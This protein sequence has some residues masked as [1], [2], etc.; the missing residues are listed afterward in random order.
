MNA[1][2]IVL[3]G[4]FVTASPLIAQGSGADAYDGCAFTTAADVEAV[5]GEKL[6]R[7]PRR[8]ILR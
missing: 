6:E 5:T 1:S 4:S 8:A 7:K 3:L 2:M